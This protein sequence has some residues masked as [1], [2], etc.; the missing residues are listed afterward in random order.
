MREQ[1]GKFITPEPGNRHFLFITIPA[2]G[3]IAAQTGHQ[4]TGDSPE[5]LVTD[6]V[7]EG[8]IDALEVIDIDK[9]N[10]HQMIVTAC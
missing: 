9:Q 2:N 10:T 8:I 6:T 5:Q 7:P 4:L 3:I 1:Y